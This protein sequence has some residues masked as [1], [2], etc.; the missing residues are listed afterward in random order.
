MIQ[1]LTFS[2]VMGFALGVLVTVWGYDQQEKQ[3]QMQ[4]AE[5][6]R[7]CL[8]YLVVTLDGRTT[9]CRL[10]Q[11][12]FEPWWPIPGDPVR[13]RKREIRRAIGGNYKETP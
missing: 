11:P 7:K 9:E 12:R 4:T 5:Q 2:A 6:V 8:G 13:L 10:L 1:R 3:K